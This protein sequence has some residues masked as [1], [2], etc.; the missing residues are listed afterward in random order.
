VWVNGQRYTANPAAIRLDAHTDIV[1]EAGPPF[2]KPPH[3][4]NWNAL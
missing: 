3:F 2:P 4:T 1:I